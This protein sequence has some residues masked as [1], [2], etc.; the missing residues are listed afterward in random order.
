[1]TTILL[2]YVIRWNNI[3]FEDVELEYLKTSIRNI[4]VQMISTKLRSFQYRL[5]THALITNIELCKYGIKETSNCTFCNLLPETIVHMFY[6]CEKAKEIW[7]YIAEII[8]LKC[9]LHVDEIVFNLVSSNPKT[10]E[11]TIVLITKQYIYRS[12]CQETEPKKEEL[13][14]VLKNYQGIEE[15]IA[16]HKNKSATHEAKW[17]NIGI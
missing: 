12:K 1:M 9:R 17:L 2:P 14:Q 8:G 5:L 13:R 3:G 15:R 11:N 4:Y 7:T 6:E 10:V 16:K